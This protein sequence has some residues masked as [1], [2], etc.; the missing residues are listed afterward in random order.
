MALLESANRARTDLPLDA[1]TAPCS[2]EYRQ[3][4]NSDL[5]VSVLAL[6]TAT[7]GNDPTEWGLVDDNESIAA[8]QTALDAGV[9]LIDTA[10]IYGNGHA[11]TVVGRAIAGRRENVIIATKCG[12][13]PPADDR[14]QLMRNLRAESIV[15]ECEASLRR[16]H[17]ENIDLYQCHW[18]DSATPE[19]ETFTALEKLKAQGKVRAIGVSNYS[20][21]QI[22]HAMEY[23]RI[24]SVQPPFSMLHR[25]PLQDLLPFCREHEIGVIAYSPLAKGLLTGKFSADSSIAGVHATDPEFRGDRYQRNL[26]FVDELRAIAANNDRS[27]AQLALRWVIQQPGVTGAIMGVKRPSQ[28]LENLAAAKS[29]IS[30]SDMCAINLL[31]EDL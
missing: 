23:A 4:G 16:L 17:V 21:E 5:R 18:P 31:L 28:V 10:P 30:E 6:G 9:N 1:H 29:A 11:E 24:A 26:R 7:M 15:A 22:L 3:L 25:R 27:P 8:I 13:L 19:Q 14:S 12:L 20:C 2:M